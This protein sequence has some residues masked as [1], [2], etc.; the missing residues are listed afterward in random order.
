MNRQPTASTI[1]VAKATMATANAVTV[2]VV[3]KAV[4]AVEAV[5][6]AAT[7]RAWAPPR[8][9]AVAVEYLVK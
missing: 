4:E 6:V 7:A 2:T 8:E 9:R 1:V 3:K 5:E